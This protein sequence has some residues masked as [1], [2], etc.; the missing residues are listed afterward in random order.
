MPRT[1]GQ[2]GACRARAF[3]FASSALIEIEVKGHRCPDLREL[4]KEAMSQSVV[5]EVKGLKAPGG[6]IQA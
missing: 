3:V 1:D 4:G 6:Q 5:I 2:P